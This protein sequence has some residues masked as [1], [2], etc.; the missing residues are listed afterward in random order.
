MPRPVTSSRKQFEN[1]RAESRQPSTHPR[2]HHR[3]DRSTWTL[4][5]SFYQLLRDQRLPLALSLATLTVATLLA[6]IPPAATKF[7]VDNVLGGKP[8]PASVPAWVPRD[9]WPLLV[10]IIIGVLAIS[11]AKL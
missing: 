9:P 6:L 11:L 7:V 2:D 5:A 4:V 3:R 1:Y 10:T 8:L